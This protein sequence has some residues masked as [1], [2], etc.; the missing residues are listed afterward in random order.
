MSSGNAG[1]N[2]PKVPESLVMNRHVTIALVALAALAAA[3]DA[4]PT[5]D[6]IDAHLKAARKAAGMVSPQR[7]GGIEPGYDWPAILAAL[8]V[9][10]ATAPTRD[11]KPGPPPP[12]RARWYTEPAKV[13]DALYFVGTKDRS[14]WVLPSSEGI[15]LIDTSFEYEA[16]QVIV[17]GLRKL[18]FDPSTVKY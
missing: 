9:A 14:S 4:Q 8:C 7:T 16:E 17:G 10:P 11:V 3:A 1:F 18:G 15:I 2:L 13:F 6:T 12:D 5:S